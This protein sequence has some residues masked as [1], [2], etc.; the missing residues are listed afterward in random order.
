MHASA[1][2][3]Q[4]ELGD[5]FVV[6]GL[7]SAAAVINSIERE[8]LAAESQLCLV[9]S[10][11]ALLRLLYLF[12]CRNGP[13]LHHMPRHTRATC[14][15]AVCSCDRDPGRSTR[16]RGREV[17]SACIWRCACALLVSGSLYPHS[18]ADGQ[19]I[20]ALAPD[21]EHDFAGPRSKRPLERL[22]LNS[23]GHES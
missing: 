5:T 15:N 19:G 20:R 10:D 17:K 22:N 13:R 6:D 11:Y 9:H 12:A 16:H 14:D 23:V 2:G 8:E 7:L 3:Q 18:H 4:T 21:V 1:L